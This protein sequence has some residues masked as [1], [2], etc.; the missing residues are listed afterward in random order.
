MLLYSFYALAT[1][2]HEPPLAKLHLPSTFNGEG[3]ETFSMPGKKTRY[4]FE[5]QRR[6][7]ILANFAAFSAICG[8]L[9]FNP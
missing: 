2:L 4:G 8:I 3:V 5:Q 6:H 9:L 7:Y 1:L